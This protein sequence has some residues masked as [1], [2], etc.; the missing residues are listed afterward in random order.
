MTVKPKITP[1]KN[2]ILLMGYF[3]QKI[4]LE[5]SGVEIMMDGNY[6]KNHRQIYWGM[7]DSE[8]SKPYEKAYTKSKLDTGYRIN[9]SFRR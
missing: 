9:E 4:A 8:K 7:Q 2:H 5:K 1:G 3:H 6:S